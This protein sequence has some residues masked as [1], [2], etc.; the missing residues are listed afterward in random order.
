ML[1]NLVVAGVLE[2]R[3]AFAGHLGWPPHAV[4]PPTSPQGLPQAAGSTPPLPPPWRGGPLLQH[5][6]PGPVC[7]RLPLGVACFYCPELLFISVEVSARV[8]A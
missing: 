5:L 1:V 6:C 8:Q 2:E 4:K 7:C 3:L